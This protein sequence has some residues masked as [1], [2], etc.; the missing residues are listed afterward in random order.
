MECWLWN[1]SKVDGV[2]PME[3]V[4]TEFERRLGYVFNDRE[5]FE[6]ALTHASYANETGGLRCNERLEFLGDAVLELS[7]SEYLYGSFP[8]LDE[9]RLSK[10]R[11]Q[12]VRE[13]TLVM[14][15]KSTCLA[16][17][18]KLSKG[19]EG[20]GGRDNPSI[21]ADA[22]EAV[23]GAVFL[24]GGYE[25]ARSVVINLIKPDGGRVSQTGEDFDRD[26]K[27]MLQEFLQA[28]GDKPPIYRLIGR[29]GPD[30]AASFKVEVTLNDGSVISSGSGNSIKAAEFA[31][32]SAA[33]SKLSGKTGSKRPAHGNA[34]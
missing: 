25:A 13:T 16:D 10:A 21:L 19:L 18:L 31:A 29:F 12:T 3:I 28:A 14:W 7:A 24:E 15:A 33:L 9:G 8:D 4:S 5:L 34:G 1:A 26:A 2:E 6:E 17:L 23:F 20:Q 11:S 22:M 27:S 32:A 30:H